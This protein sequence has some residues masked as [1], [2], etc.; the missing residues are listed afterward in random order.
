MRGSC[1][2]C[3][4]LF[5]A[6]TPP[7]LVELVLEHDCPVRPAVGYVPEADRAGRCGALSPTPIVPADGTPAP[8]RL[9]CE[10]RAGHAG[11]HRA[12]QYAGAPGTID[13]GFD[14]DWQL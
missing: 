7:A 9:S 2:E 1:P 11:W 5:E 6:R 12:R 10:L 3:G 8:A 14:V 13:A 4:E